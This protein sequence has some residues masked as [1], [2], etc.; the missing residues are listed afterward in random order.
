[1]TTH[2]Q[3]KEPGGTWELIPNAYAEPH[4][5][6]CD[7][8]RVHVPADSEFGARLTAAGP[9][10]RHILIADRAPFV[11]PDMWHGMI[12]TWTHRRGNLVID[13]RPATPAER[14]AG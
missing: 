11:I 5:D 1:M 4:C 9:R 6:H 7:N 3:T 8:Y 14:A 2:V 13:V 10:R 12:R